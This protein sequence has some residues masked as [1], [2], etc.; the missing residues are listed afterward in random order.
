MEGSWNRTF[1]FAIGKAK[2]LSKNKVSLVVEKD[3]IGAIRHYVRLGFY[4]DDA[5]DS[6]H[7]L[8]HRMILNI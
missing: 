1:K 6:K 3:N 2:D 7:D 4:V 8:V 5:N